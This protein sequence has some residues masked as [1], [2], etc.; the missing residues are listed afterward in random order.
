MLSI[1][2]VLNRLGA[3]INYL[4]IRKTDDYHIETGDCYEDILVVTHLLLSLTT[5]VLHIK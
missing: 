5:C 4:T 1:V 3:V 2:N